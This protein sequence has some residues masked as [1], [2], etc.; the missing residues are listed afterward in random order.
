MSYQCVCINEYLDSPSTTA[1]GIMSMMKTSGS[2]ASPGFMKPEGIVM[3][4]GPSN[5]AFKKTFEYDEYGK[6]M[7]NQVAKRIS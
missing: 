7:E 6:W 4:H 2:Y 5:T 1:I 3:F